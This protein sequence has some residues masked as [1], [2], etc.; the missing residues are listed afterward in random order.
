MWAPWGCSVPR[1]DPSDCPRLA[2]QPCVH[3]Q[4]QHIGTKAGVSPL[5]PE[6]QLGW[7]TL[8]TPEMADHLT[9]TGLQP[10][11]PVKPTVTGVHRRRTQWTLLAASA[12]M[13]RQDGKDRARDPERRP[14]ALS[15]SV[16]SPHVPPVI[17][18]WSGQ[19]RPRL[20]PHTQTVKCCC[21]WR[22]P[23]TFLNP[24]ICT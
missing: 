22:H 17:G 9:P 2:G 8:G 12:P 15:P 19:S 20:D 23:D 14:L 3:Y 10:G 13:A 1:H 11:R 18:P 4:A 21:C 6:R 7:G 24:Q 5:V 16:P